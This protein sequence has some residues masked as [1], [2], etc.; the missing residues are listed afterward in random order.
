VK[1][2]EGHKFCKNPTCKK[3]FRIFS[4]LTKFCSIGCKK[5]VEGNK[6]IKPISTK[7]GEQTKEYLLLREVYLRKHPTCEI[8]LE[9]CTYKSTEI[10]HARKRV[11]TMLTNTEYFVAT[12]RSC[13]NNAHDQNLKLK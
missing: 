1:A 4:T 5:S 9:G 13:H 6:R 10:H 12:C 3:E 11:G 2:K 7:R 8:A